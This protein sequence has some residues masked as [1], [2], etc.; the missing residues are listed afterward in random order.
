MNIKNKKVFSDNY[1]DSCVYYF[2][3]LENENGLKMIFDMFTNTGYVFDSFMPKYD[4]DHS[5]YEPDVTYK[6]FEELC[7]GIGNGVMPLNLESI[8]A[9]GKYLDDRACVLDINLFA[10]YFEIAV[11]KK[12]T[13]END[14][15]SKHI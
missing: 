6:S 7:I 2:D 15:S 10:K 3:L 9:S 11:E 5:D 12:N 13:L 1:K 4:R 14:Y 8:V